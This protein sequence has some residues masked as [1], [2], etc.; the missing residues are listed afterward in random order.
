VRRRRRIIVG[1]TGATGIAY[2]IRV[3]EFLRAMALVRD[4]QFCGTCHTSYR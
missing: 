1:I 3:L 2:G 4:W